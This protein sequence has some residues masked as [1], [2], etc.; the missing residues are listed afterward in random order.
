MITEVCSPAI[1]VVLL[2]LAVAWR[3]TG[4]RIGP[5]VGWG[6]VVAVFSSVLPN[7]T[8]LLPDWWGVYGWFFG[9]GIAGA[10]YYA[11]RA[12]EPSPVNKPA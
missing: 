12:A 9:V 8:S 10:V 5:T 1:V 7:F 2:P 3:A 11:L 6:L 4:Y